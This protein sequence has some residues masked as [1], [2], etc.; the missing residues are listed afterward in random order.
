MP[1]GTYT[2]SY[3]PQGVYAPYALTTP[4][5]ISVNA[6]TVG[7][8][9]GGNHFGLY[10][11]PGTVNL[12]VNL[13]PHTTVTPGH[14]AWYSVQVCNIGLIPTAATLTMNYDPGLTLD[15][16]QPAAASNNTVNHILTW[17]LAVINPGSCIN[18]WVD[19][20]ASTSY[21]VGSNT[22]EFVSVLPVTG[23]DIDLSNNTDTVHQVVT[24]SW[25]P[26]NKLSI[27][28]NNIN[29]NEQIVSAVNPDQEI[30]YTVNFQNTGTAPAVN[31]VVDDAL[32]PDLDAASFQLVGTSHPCSVTR[33]GSQVQYVFSQIM[34]PDSA[35]NEPG[36]HGFVCFR[37]SAVNGLAAGHVISDEAAI[38]FDFNIPVITNFSTVTMVNPLGIGESAG[39]PHHLQAYPNPSDGHTSLSFRLD[40]PGDVR[41]DLVDGTGRK[42][43]SVEAGRLDAG[44]HTLTVDA[45]GLPA[46]LYLLRLQTPAGA[47]TFKITKL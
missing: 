26:N 30:V 15:Y 45:T 24:A 32:S 9:Y 35:T 14:P 28:T 27:Q 18:V 31:V 1:A 19:F 12:S 16:S 22:F 2:V 39:G 46:G 8:T 11:P 47:S 21:V 25:D 33:F 6:T 38:Y 41:L 36:S 23:T 7:N 3:S 37:V 44:S 29:P 34:L 40:S 5:S 10:I 20:D 42:V 43:R 4:G 13:I 17:N